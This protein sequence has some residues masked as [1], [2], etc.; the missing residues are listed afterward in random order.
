MADPTP[1]DP[2][3]QPV[4][5]GYLE[6]DR[7]SHLAPVPNPSNPAARRPRSTRPKAHQRSW[8]GDI[9][10][11]DLADPNYNPDAWYTATRGA[12]KMSRTIQ[13][14]IPEYSAEAI[15]QIV[16]RRCFPAVR[17][18][19]DFIR[20]AIIHELHRRL[21][22]IRD[23][24]F[25]I[26]PSAHTDLAEINALRAE[27]EAMKSFVAYCRDELAEVD[28]SPT[29]VRRVLELVWAAM[30]SG[31][32]DG[33]LYRQLEDISKKYWDDRG[34]SKRPRPIPPESE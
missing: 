34:F 1:L 24:N 22:E 16:A 8:N 11:Y 31:L 19:Q 15:D 23:P 33:A 30:E 29:R 12:D 27:N 2:P 13:V 4:W 5:G 25:V 9:D 18:N 21:G 20:S 7:T 10:S 28:G 6:S 14:R 17:T 26:R 3:G 32:Y